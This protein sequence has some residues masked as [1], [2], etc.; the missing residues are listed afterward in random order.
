MSIH[1]RYMAEWRRSNL[2]RLVPGGATSHRLERLREGGF[3]NRRIAREAGVSVRT[4]AHIRSGTHLRIRRSTADAIAALH[5]TTNSD[6]PRVAGADAVM[7][8]I[9][10]LLGKRETWRAKGLC[11]D[12][13]Y[14]AEWW[15]PER[16]DPTAPGKAICRRCPVID[17]CAAYALDHK[18]LSGIW[19]ATTGDDRRR[20]H[21]ERIRE[22]EAG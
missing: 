11:R 3:S 16:G 17:P 5:A 15:F 9:A 12:K 20:I 1:A 10:V 4:V 18:E 21:G 2:S 22:R 8:T 13:R 19:G 14:P 7:E 6:R